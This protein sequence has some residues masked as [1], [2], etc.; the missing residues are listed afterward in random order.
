[1]SIDLES[2]GP[3]VLVP[4]IPGMAILG[5]AGLLLVLLTAVSVVVAWQRGTLEDQL[6]ENRKAARAADVAT[7][8]AATRPEA[9]PPD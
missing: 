4:R 9:G 7:D 3:S 8:P 2:D 5:G 1:M 6:E